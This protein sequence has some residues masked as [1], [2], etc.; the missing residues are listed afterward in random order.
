[1]S[2]YNIHTYIYT[3]TSINVKRSLLKEILLEEIHS[4][5]MLR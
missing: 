1:M 2:L 4:S 5:Y 3:G